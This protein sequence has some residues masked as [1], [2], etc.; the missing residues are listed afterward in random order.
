MRHSCHRQ[1]V[2]VQPVGRRLGLLKAICS[3]DLPFNG[4]HPPNPC[5]YMDYYSFTDPGG[6]KGWVGLVG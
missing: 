1:R 2:G 5:N 3:L 4:C 6:R